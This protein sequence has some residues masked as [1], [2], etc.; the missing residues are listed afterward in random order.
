MKINKWTL[1]LAAVGLVTIPTVMQAEE[2]PLSA[3]QTL[4]SSTT[5]SGYVD[6]SADWTIGNGHGNASPAGYAFNTP[7]KQDGFNLN[8]V[9]VMLQKLPDEKENW[10][11][12][13]TIDMVYGPN[14]VGYNTSV[15]SAGSD[16]ALKQAYVELVAPV[17][18]GLH[19]KMGTFDS[20]IGY[21][22]YHSY[23][24]PNYTRSYGYSIEPTELTG[25]LLQYA[26]VKEVVLSA[27]VA[28]T[29]NAGIN[30]RS[31]L[32]GPGQPKSE[33]DKTYMGAIT[34]TAPDSMG[35]L[36]G[37]QLYGGIVNGFNTSA[38][39]TGDRSGQ[40]W[41]YAGAF[42]KTPIKE[43]TVGVAYDYTSINGSASGWTVNST[44]PPPPAP[45]GAAGGPKAWLDAVSVYAS[46]AATEKLKF[47]VRGEYAW[48]KDG[49]ANYLNKVAG[50]GQSVG[51]A[52][53]IFAVT[54][55]IEYDLWANVISRV[56]FRWDHAADGTSPYSGSARNSCLLA[57]NVIYKF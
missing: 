14:A 15:G 30:N 27:G 13:Y 17:G 11:A 33:S 46:Y 54:G 1:G 57:A 18:N 19:A 36:A 10:A 4:V 5:I 29:A 3:L 21:E 55:T 49:M 56:E 20:I 7:S 52:D 43:L 48:M 28:D 40:T 35:F 45:A 24:N 34:L 22:A 26:V 25:L 23:K 32:G 6:T 50:S 51:L 31:F 16:F 44:P 8:A 39:G 47:H 53:K 41:Y 37:S 2:K 42:I 9:N 12:G 38:F